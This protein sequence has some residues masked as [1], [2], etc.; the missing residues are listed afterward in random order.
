MMGKIVA[1]FEAKYPNYKVELEFIP[2]A[3]YTQ[4][5]IPSLATDTAPDVF[6]IQQ[7]MVEKLAEVGS[8]KPLRSE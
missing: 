1:M 6:Q 3:D 7:G 4:K 8:I 5:L 2:Q